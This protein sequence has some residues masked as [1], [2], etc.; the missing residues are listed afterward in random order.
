MRRIHKPPP[1]I[2]DTR[3]IKRLLVFPTRIGNESRWLEVG[4]I[5]QLFSTEP[6]DFP[7]WVDKKWA[8]SIVDNSARIADGT[9]DD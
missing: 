9:S 6:L 2:G 4:S 5:V 1:I 3:I 8:D 7:G